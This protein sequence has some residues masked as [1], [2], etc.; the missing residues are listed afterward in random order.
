MKKTALIIMVITVASKILGLG[1]E[2]TLSYFYGVS[3]ISDAYLL[4]IT[5]PAV[6]MGF[7]GAVISTGFIPMFSNLK[8]NYGIT[9]G[10][11][12]TNNVVNLL[13][14]V[15]TVIV[16]LGLLYTN[17][18]VRLFASGFEG[19][20]LELAVNF[21]RIS[22]L[23][24][25]FSSLLLVFCD[26]LKVNGSYT[27]PILIGFPLNIL[28]ITSIFL[29][30]NQSVLILSIGSLVAIASQ[31]IFILPFVLK[32]GYSYKPI[33]NMKDEHV[34]NMLYIA[35]P[36]MIGVT[37]N[38][39]N[40]LVD[41]TLASQIA[42]GGISAIT[43]AT[44]LNTFVQGIFVV[45]IVTVMYPVISKFAAD[46]NMLDFKKSISESIS[47]I[48]LFVLPATVISMI[49][50]QPLVKLIFGRGEFGADAISMTASVLFFYSI[51]MVGFGLRDVLSKAFYSLQDTK[52][53][54]I[55]GIISMVINIVLN[56]ILSRFLGLGGLALATSISAILC[57]GL[58][59]ISLRR[60]IGSLGLK[61][62]CVTFLKLLVASLLMGMVAKLIYNLFTDYIGSNISLLT[63]LGVGGVV[64]LVIVYYMKIED[65][66]TL[67][68][69][70]KRK[71]VGPRKNIR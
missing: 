35:I 18:L 44:R 8:R 2:I 11:R 9:I 68:S 60:K 40:V 10:N 51:G 7:I 42:V 26:Y 1:R 16:L 66:V 38:Q 28:T 43:Y 46:N 49:F 39:L 62:L 3:S 56:V 20:T 53:P 30:K 55:N 22:I 37:V 70:F 64:Y 6:I 41:R 48:N 67:V 32:K 52:T 25:Y 69:S 17:Q 57:T 36:V 23:S 4:S 29:S 24:I 13:L 71:L 63:S 65:A 21:T 12:Y 58:L 50:A 19:E 14:I 45:S 27:I 54:M 34:R 15:C 61:N 33:L 31:L 5:I 59:F 47:G